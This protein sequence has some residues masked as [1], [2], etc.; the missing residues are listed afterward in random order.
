MELH[1]MHIRRRSRPKNLE[2]QPRSSAS[3]PPRC[4]LDR[5]DDRTTA[6]RDRSSEMVGHA[7]DPRRG[8]RNG[9]AAESSRDWGLCE[10]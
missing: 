10:I 4:C 7:R 3:R 9:F 1:G 5:T 2:R 6:F 8:F